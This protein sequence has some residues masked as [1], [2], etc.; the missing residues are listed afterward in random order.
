M[1]GIEPR[2]Q[3]TDSVQVFQ[4][5]VSPPG[6]VGKLHAVLFLFLGNRGHTAAL[7]RYPACPAH[8]NLAT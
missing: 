2:G 5:S 7:V 3:V 8:R 4:S 1:V 6:N